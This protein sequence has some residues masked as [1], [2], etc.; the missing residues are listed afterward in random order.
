LLNA[1]GP[2]REPDNQG[3]ER[4]I[5]SRVKHNVEGFHFANTMH[6]DLTGAMSSRFELPPL[7][8]DRSRIF[9]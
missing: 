2:I 6:A 7:N 1:Q 4:I 8:R 5:A 3:V 9:D